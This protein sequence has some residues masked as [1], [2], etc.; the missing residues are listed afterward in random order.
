MSSIKWSLNGG[1]MSEPH[2]PEIT[3][4]RCGSTKARIDS[5]GVYVPGWW[6]PDEYHDRWVCDC[7][8]HGIIMNTVSLYKKHEWFENVNGEWRGK[9]LV[10]H[11]TWSL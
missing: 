5:N 8:V 3:C 9:E 2:I 4:P 6:I 10:I 7:G 1:K 11:G